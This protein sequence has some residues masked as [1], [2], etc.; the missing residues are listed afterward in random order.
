MSKRPRVLALALVLTVAPF[1]LALTQDAPQQTPTTTLPA[2]TVVA[3]K[4]RVVVRR[5]HAAAPRPRTAVAP[6]PAAAAT[7]A[8]AI[9]VPSTSAA[10]PGLGNAP[11]QTTTTVSRDQFNDTPAFSIGDVLQDSPGI[12]I[13]QSNGPRDVG[14]SI[15]GS[16]AQ[17]TYAIRNIVVLED[18]FPVTQPDGLA[19]SDI[20]D[21][22]A[23]SGIDIF[24]GP[25]SA[26][27]GNYATGGAIDFHT[28][29]GNQIDG[30]QFGT[31]VGS[32]GYVNNYLA[33][34]G[35]TGPLDY[36]LFVSN[37]R[38]DGFIANS[39]FDTPT[40]NFLATYAVTPND[41]ITTK[42]ISNYVGTELPIRLS[43]NQ[44]QQNPFQKGCAVA[45]TA[46]PGCATITLFANG[47]SGATESQTAEQAGLGR[48]DFRNIVG[49][50]WEH[51]F[52]NATSWQTQLLFDDK[53]INQ[54]TGT[55]SAIGNTP[56]L[57][58]M[59]SVI[60]KD[61][62]WGLDFTHFFGLF[63]N[64]EGLSNFTYNLAPGGNA[65]LGALS[66]YYDSGQQENVGARA[67]EQ[68]KFNDSWTG[69]I[70]ADIEHTNITTVDNIFSFPS[71]VPTPAPFAIDRDFLNSAEEADLLYRLNSDWQFRGRVATGYGTPQI[72]NLTVTPQGV[73]GDNSQLSSQT[74]I[75]YDLGT[76]WTPLS[77]LKLSVTGFYEFFRN[78]LV[79]QSPGAGLLSYTFNAPASQH[80]GVE[81][82]LDWQPQPGWR[83]ITAY[84][85]LDEFFTDYI[86]QL[87]SGTFTERF[88]RAGNF[89]PGV[90]PNELLTR[91]GYDQPV[92]PW[93]GVGAFVQ[94]QWKDA[95][96]IDNANLLKIP[97][98]ELVNLN[99]HY[100]VNLLTSNYFKSAMLYFEVRNIFNKT[101][102]ASANNISDSLNSTT[103][104]ENPG[105]V[106]ATSGTGSIYAG[107]PR[108][109]VAGVRFAFR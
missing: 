84:T 65:T 43:L 73:S 85:Y 61:S 2:V 24:R 78:E 79:T 12:D 75:G 60:H 69:I 30:F 59:S 45:A 51:D 46:A 82:A 21:P 91:L 97:G 22:H 68:I 90:S 18:G 49:V 92:G 15:R 108:T 98:Y 34:G 28:R 100:N 58:V 67:R 104:A 1:S 96:F 7:P 54:P 105:S 16:N 87:S 47:Y 99:I 19:R 29:T 44:F 10:T 64:I 107:E 4:H 103:G 77:T 20:T 72:S 83:L 41:I 53:D 40:V 13:K 62:L 94:F 9:A 39:A 32:F 33:F 109:F 38:G 80:R 55:T 23:Y 88:N 8:P 71:G 52:D 56:A 93:Q 89:L 76:D 37:V 42:V 36:S 5:R 3:P 57:N 31:D 81:A 35:H 17:N 48:H 26:Y 27:F 86:E 106:L 70:G 66:S 74:N 63:Y 25:S 95:Y 11:G 50:R 6:A 101:Y 14:I 102:V